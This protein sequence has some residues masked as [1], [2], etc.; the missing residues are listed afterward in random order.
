VPVPRNQVV[1]AGRLA[2]A[3]ICLFA[4]TLSAQVGYDPEQ[5]PYQ[6]LRIT[7]TVTAFGG[8]MWGGEGKAGVGPGPGLMGGLRWDIHVGGFASVFLGGTYSELQRVLLDPSQPPA[9]RTIDTTTQS[10]TYFDFGANL[11]FTGRKT[12]HGLM[13]YI[14]A[15][16]GI[17]IGGS[18]PED[19]LSGY[20]FKTKF[21]FGPTG[22]FRLFLTRRL[23]FRT[24]GRVIFWQ[25]SYPNVFFTPGID[26]P[27]APILD[28]LT[29]TEKEWVTH[30]TLQFGLG[31]SIRL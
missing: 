8:N 28:P 10:V 1:F 22:G 15:A 17:A 27:V 23:H 2:L 3:S 18:V 11:L 13:P 5:S 25:L 6:D 12:W 29:N 19:S 20:T 9:T 24:E 14:G 16:A 7:Q 21:Q 30:L 4:T 31:Y 26:P